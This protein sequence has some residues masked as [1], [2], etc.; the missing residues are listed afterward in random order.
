[1]KYFTFIL[2]FLLSTYSQAIYPSC[3]VVIEKRNFETDN[4]IFKV[5]INLN[6][7]QKNWRET[8][9]SELKSRNDNQ[10]LFGYLKDYCYPN[11][12][13]YKKFKFKINKE[14]L[15]GINQQNVATKLIETM[16]FKFDFGL[17]KS[18]IHIP[19]FTTSKCTFEIF[20]YEFRVEDKIQSNEFRKFRVQA[21][22]KINILPVSKGMIFDDSEKDSS[23][24]QFKNKLNLAIKKKD[25]TLLQSL[26]ANKIDNGM[27][28]Y[29]L[30]SE[31]FNYNDN[32][33]ERL[34]RVL[35]FGFHSGYG[36]TLESLADTTKYT[37]PFYLKQL[38]ISRL[39]NKN[40][41]AVIADNLNVRKE[42]NLNSTVISKVSYGLFQP[43]FDKNYEI[44][45]IF[46]N[47]ISWIKIQLPNNHSGFIAKKYTSEYQFDTLVISKI[48][49]EW[50]ITAFYGDTR[51]W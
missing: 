44:I 16:Q 23:L 6:G 11:D 25:S 40:R 9:T 28:D 46:N 47:N 24:K 50:K 7:S 5:L 15:S 41:I 27:M 2:I 20:D 34:D 21:S 32:V 26:L 14:L 39:N 19:K 8:R 10:I 48:K 13:T 36:E 1:M 31:F 35:G 30:K 38:N 49:N 22:S 29:Y 51:N 3:E 33:W 18:I 17:G 43:V 37:A 4:F 42:P 45:E 12:F